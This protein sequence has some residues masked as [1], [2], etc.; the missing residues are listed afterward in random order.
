LISLDRDSARERLPVHLGSGRR[1][2]AY[3]VPVQAE[4][5]LTNTQIS[6][7]TVAASYAEVVRGKVA[8][9]PYFRAIF[10]LFA[11]LVNANGSGP[12]ADVG[13]GPGHIT[14]YLRDIGV[15]AFGIDLSPAMVELARRDYP[16]LRFEVGSMTEL[17][18]ADVS[19]AGLIAWYSV[20]HVPDDV[21]PRVFAHF[22]RVVRPG[23]VVLLG[24]HAGD[25]HR[26]KTSGYGGHPMSVH[27]Y[28]RPPDRVAAL[29][30]DAGL[31]VEARIVQEPPTGAPQAFLLARRRD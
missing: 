10:T 28:L 1:I 29:L 19:V 27:L 8:D 12:V 30:Q 13:C 16:E 24:F 26:L 15:D 31:A 18:L 3:G 17:A 4:D 25:E 11:E 20:I 14:A 6:Y 22:R 5:W 21:I 9:L 23:G 7:D 2:E